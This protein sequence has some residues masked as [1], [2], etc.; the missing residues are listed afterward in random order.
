MQQVA[1]Q[2]DPLAVKHAARAP[3]VPV[4]FRDQTAEVNFLALFFLLDF[5]SGEIEGSSGISLLLLAWHC[6]TIIH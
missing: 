3:P 2:L 1:G 6:S 4:S 5:G